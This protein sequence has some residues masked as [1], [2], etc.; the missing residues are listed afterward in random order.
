[1]EL[2]Y[3]AIGWYFVFLLAITIHE[4]AH[5]YV[6]Y[7]GGDSTAYNNGQVTLNPIPHIKHEPV[8]TVVV[9]IIALFV[10]GWPL[11]FASAPYDPLW[12][13]RHPYRAGLMALAGPASNLLLTMLATVLIWIGLFSGVFES[14]ASIQGLD[15]VVTAT[16]D[17]VWASLANVLSIVFSLN[18]LLFVFNLFP[19]PPLDGSGVISL[20][21]P[22]KAAVKVQEFLHNPMFSLIGLLIA[23]KTFW[24]VFDPIFVFAWNILH[25]FSGYG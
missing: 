4:A 9:P 23:W 22:E 15:H 11:G 17:G 3:E 20:L 2:G 21:L 1:M 24:Y 6:A 19:F 5:A 13:G 18:L 7:L 16:S 12:A 10:M 14:P 8:G 25:P